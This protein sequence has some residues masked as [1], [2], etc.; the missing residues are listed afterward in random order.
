MTNFHFN[1]LFCAIWQYLLILC[2]YGAFP[3]ILRKKVFRI[4]SQQWVIH[5]VSFI[6]TT[7]SCL[8]NIDHLRIAPGECHHGNTLNGS[9][10]QFYLLF[11][12]LWWWNQFY[13]QCFYH[14]GDT[15]TTLCH[16]KV[17]IGTNWILVYSCNQI[18]SC[19]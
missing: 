17:D 7:L 13:V 16:R 9:A 8:H 11:G 10:E 2:I 12:K 4:C 19:Y 1:Y 14:H 18:F 15:C 6:W 5:N 3:V